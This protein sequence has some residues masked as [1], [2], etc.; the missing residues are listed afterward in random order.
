MRRFLDRLYT[1][2]G[3][4][5]AL[6]L[7]GICV[8]M[9]AQAIGARARRAADPRLGRHHFV[10]VRGVRV[11]GARPY[12]PP[13]RTGARRPVHR[14]AQGRAAPLG[15][16]R[17][18]FVHRAVR[19]LHGLGGIE[20]RLGK[21][22]VQRGRARPDQAADL[23]SADELRAGGADLPRSPCSTNWSRCCS[24]ASPPT[25]SPRKSGGRRVISR[26]WREH[27]HHR[28]R[29]ARAAAGAAVG[30]RVDR[31]LARG[32]GLVRPAVLHQH[33]AG[34]EPVPVVLGLERLVDARGAAAVHLDGRNPV[35]HQAFGR[36]VRRPGALAQLAA[37]PADARQY[38]R[39]RHLRHRVGLLGRYLRDHRQGRAAGA[40]QAR[41]RREDLPRIAVRRGHARHPAAA[42]DHHGGVRGGGGSL[43]PQGVP[44]GLPAGIPAD[45]AV[46]RLHHRLGAA[47]SG[48]DAETRRPAHVRRKTLQEPAPDSLPCA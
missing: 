34:R 8:L 36:D 14:R 29:A 35:P 27:A 21:L 16:D 3:A 17:R 44:R 39:L 45:G 20:I 9:L 38:P 1:A 6:C 33:A 41:L 23:D 13:R 32:G 2:S 7:A 22:E 11:L 30:R 43:D 37:R 18:A 47:Q 5:A 15:R 40:D 12:L 4:F 48:Q 24:G 46:L 28:L 26:R 25:R 10:A 31:D 42:L 19:R